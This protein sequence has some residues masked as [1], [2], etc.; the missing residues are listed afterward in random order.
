MDN[1]AKAPLVVGKTIGAITNLIVVI[2]V[3]FNFFGLISFAY[4]ARDSVS[5]L[6]TGMYPNGP[7]MGSTFLDLF[8]H[9]WVAVLLGIVLLATVAKE[10]II[11][12]IRTRLIINVGLFVLLL[13]ID[14]LLVRG[15]TAPI[16]EAS[17]VEQSK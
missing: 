12:P 11:K 13:A 3:S 6:S 4:E 7:L 15:Y 10:F 17:N 2:L 8:L 16:R 1:V 5:G 9:K 14:G